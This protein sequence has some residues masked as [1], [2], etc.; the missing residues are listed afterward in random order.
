MQGFELLHSKSATAVA[1]RNVFNTTFSVHIFAKSWTIV[2]Q[3]NYDL[4]EDLCLCKEYYVVVLMI[5]NMCYL[6][7]NERRKEYLTDDM[8]QFNIISGS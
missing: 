2:H 6:T 1:L 8:S 5:L 3:I 4:F 7:L